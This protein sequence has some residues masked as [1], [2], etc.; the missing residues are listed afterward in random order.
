MACCSALFSSA[1]TF[2]A[3]S[4]YR[5]RNSTKSKI[6]DSF[7]NSSRSLSSG[8][9]STDWKTVTL[10]RRLRTT[11]RYAGAP[12]VWKLAQAG[13]TSH[14]AHS[15]EL[16]KNG[17]ICVVTLTPDQQILYPLS[18]RFRLEV[19]KDVVRTWNEVSLP[20]DAELERV[21]GH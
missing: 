14:C 20:I 15:Q 16:E 3:H 13:I 18:K 8:S 19:S 2:R 4:L 7:G 17:H 9:S 5:S 6:V 21:R 1:P 12:T 10:G 11:Y